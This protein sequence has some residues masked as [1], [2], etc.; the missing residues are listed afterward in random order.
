MTSTFFIQYRVPYFRYVGCE[1]V[2]LVKQDYVSKSMHVVAPDMMHAIVKFYDAIG[3]H[4][5]IS[6][7]ELMGKGA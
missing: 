7:I 5:V 1:G 2:P 6:R 4:P 3:G